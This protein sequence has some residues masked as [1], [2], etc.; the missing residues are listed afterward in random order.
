MRGAL[1]WTALAIAPFV[2]VATV[3]AIA[4]AIASLRLPPAAEFAASD[5]QP[6]RASHVAPAV[7]ERAARRRL[8]GNLSC[9]PGRG[10]GAEGF[11]YI[12]SIR[13]RTSEPV[14]LR[15]ADNGSILGLFIPPTDEAA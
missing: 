12:C 15:V 8:A 10:P 13:G 9:H 14:F 1:A 2:I 4:V 6:Y 11:N 7:V 5:P 3:V